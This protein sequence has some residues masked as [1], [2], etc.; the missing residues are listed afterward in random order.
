MKKIIIIILIIAA[1]VP[2]FSASAGSDLSKRVEELEKDVEYLT[3]RIEEIEAVLYVTAPDYP[4]RYTITERSCEE[5]KTNFLTQTIIYVADCESERIKEQYYEELEY[6]ASLDGAALIEDTF[7]LDTDSFY[8]ELL[9]ENTISFDGSIGKYEIK[10]GT[11]YIDGEE[12]G[13]ITHDVISFTIEDDSIPF[14]IKFY[15]TAP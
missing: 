12:F 9:D 4:V 6:I 13:I 11:L 3:K 2:V 8:I 15:R 7:I 1:V 5:F 10:N 14:T